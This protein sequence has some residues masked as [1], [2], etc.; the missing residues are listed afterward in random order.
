MENTA[1]VTHGFKASSEL[2]RTRGGEVYVGWLS[3]PSE[4]R[5][6]TYRATGLKCFRLGVELFLR[7]ADRDAASALDYEIEEASRK[8]QGGP[9]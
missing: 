1:S 5:I 3:H 2:Y 4:D 7:E 6:K 8:A 9:K